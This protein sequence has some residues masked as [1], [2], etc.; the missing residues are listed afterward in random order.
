MYSYE[1][2]V[3]RNS[4][5]YRALQNQDEKYWF[6][7]EIHEIETKSIASAV[8]SSQENCIYQKTSK[9]RSE[10]DLLW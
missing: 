5:L 7:P 1:L 2:T 8:C 4:I 3:L 9:Y 6:S 10:D